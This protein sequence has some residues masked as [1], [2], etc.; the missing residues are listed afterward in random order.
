LAR[1]SDAKAAQRVGKNIH[2]ICSGSRAG[3]N[4]ISSQATRL[5][6]Q[7]HPASTLFLLFPDCPRKERPF[8][9]KVQ[10]VV[11]LF[12]FF[13]AIF[14]TGDLEMTRIRLP[15]LAS[16]R[17]NFSHVLTAE[18]R[19]IVKI[20]CSARDHEKSV[21]KIPSL[22]VKDGSARRGGTIPN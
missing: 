22:P 2:R 16:R 20:L 11:H 8:Y 14:E 5:P 1:R 7:G 4:G 6:L 9:V 3:C 18:V 21:W 12:L 19:K 13:W 17:V 15:W 10:K